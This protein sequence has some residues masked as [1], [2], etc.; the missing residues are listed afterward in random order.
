MLPDVPDLGSLPLLAP[1]TLVDSALYLVVVLKVL[2]VWHDTG[3]EILAVY[4]IGGSEVL[5]DG[6]ETGRPVGKDGR[7]AVYIVTDFHC[8]FGEVD[9]LDYLPVLLVGAIPIGEDVDLA[10]FDDED[11][12]LFVVDHQFLIGSK[13]SLL[14]PLG[15]HVLHVFAP[16]AEEED[17]GLDHVQRV[18]EV[19]L[20]SEILVELHQHPVLVLDLE[21]LAI[22]LVAH[23]E[24]LGL[25]LQLAFQV[26]VLSNLANS[27]DIPL[28]DLVFLPDLG[29]SVA[30]LVEQV[31]EG[32]DPNDLNDNGDHLLL[33]ILGTD[34]PIANGKHGGT[35]KVDGVDVLRKEP[36]ALNPN[37]L[38][39]VMVRVD[40]G[41]TVEHYS[42]NRANGTKVWAWMKMLKSRS[43]I[44]ISFSYS[45]PTSII[46]IIP[47][48]WAAF[49][50]RK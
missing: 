30:H 6:L 5:S 39:P 14:Q 8:V 34:I 40:L 50:Y 46:F 26:V 49:L 10:F 25:V 38:D 11:S 16:V 31:A 29:K 21:L 22:L 47:Y 32:N 44:L 43:M 24:L 4:G 48:I 1:V 18:L 9:D 7:V 27:L 36:I 23:D 20:I 13:H 33:N 12:L 37:A 2:P 45:K 17:A 28:H 3:K 15:D 35:G 42:L 19:Y 41:S